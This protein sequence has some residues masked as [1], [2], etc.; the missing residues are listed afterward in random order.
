MSPAAQS[1]PLDTEL[2]RVADL[3]RAMI[4]EYVA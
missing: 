1:S 3:C 4:D 2:A